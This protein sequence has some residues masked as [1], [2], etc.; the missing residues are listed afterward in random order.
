MSLHLGMVESREESLKFIK[1]IEKYGEAEF[2]ANLLRLSE[3]LT[4]TMEY[5]LVK[6]FLEEKL[7]LTKEEAFD[8]LQ[9]SRVNNFECLFGFKDLPYS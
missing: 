1:K 4:E 3:E 8:W 2:T 7:L 5:E 9:K 6:L